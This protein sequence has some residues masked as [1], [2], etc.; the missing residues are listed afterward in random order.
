[1]RFAHLADCHLGGWRQPEL[2]ELNLKSFT[3]AIDLCIEK[4]IDFALITGDLFDSA[5][6]PIEI[7]EEA[8]FQLK[9]LKE[10]DI[11]CYIIAGSHDY[12]ASGKTFLSVLEKAGFCKNIYS[13]EERQGQIYLNPI[14]HENVALY[15]YPGKKSGM[16]VQELKGIKLHESPGLFRIFALHTCIEDAMGTL[17]IESVKESELPQADYYALGHLHIDYE[18]GRFVYA[19]P[20]FPN[21]FQELEELNYGSFYIV[22]TSPF[23]LEKIWLKLKDVVIVEMEITNALVGTDKI[24]SELQKKEL[25]DKILL[26]KL[27]GVL[28]Q[29]KTSDIDFKKIEEFA[30]AQGA[31][32]ILKSTSKLEAKEQQIEI[33]VE[34]MNKLEEEIVKKYSSQNP[35]K[36]NPLVTPLMSSLSIEKQE[37]ETSLTFQ[38]RL[39]SELF[40]V[41]NLE[42]LKK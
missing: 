6:P 19:G 36:F 9:K 12:S 37:D 13:P 7:L 3:R 2:Q 35:T 30:R 22:D 25:K 41:L 39:F 32:S 11:P 18:Q 1:M 27:S 23:K 31:F 5:Y 24:T 15:G 42:Y 21:N 29:G 26:M 20:T 16:E 14:L 4:N 33:Q 34:D 10:A 40:K 28:Q 17:P 8:F 38:T